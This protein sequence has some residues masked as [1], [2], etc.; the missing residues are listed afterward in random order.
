MIVETR[1]AAPVE[2]SAHRVDLEHSDQPAE[3][4]ALATG[5]ASA[6]VLRSI[7][8][9][10]TNQGPRDLRLPG[11]FGW[12]LRSFERTIVLRRQRA[13]SRAGSE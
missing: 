1:A 11:G 8:R 10:W 5:F 13:M 6:G 9:R 2:P 4:I 7:L 12:V 3:R